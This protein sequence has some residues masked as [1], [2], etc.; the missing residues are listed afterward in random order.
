VARFSS[1]KHGKDEYRICIMSRYL[2]TMANKVFR[3]MNLMQLFNY[4]CLALSS[5]K[6]GREY[7][8]SRRVG[9][10]TTRCLGRVLSLRSIKTVALHGTTQNIMTIF[11]G[12]PSLGASLVAY[13]KSY[14]R[15][16]RISVFILQHII[17]SS[18]RGVS[19]RRQDAKLLYA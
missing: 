2:V 16:E 4:L 17:M 7:N 19:S 1:T 3:K 13:I 6:R 5:I 14:P 18:N 9:C 8:Q 11:L 12:T 10:F 15:A